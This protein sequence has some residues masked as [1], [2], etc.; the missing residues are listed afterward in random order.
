[1]TGPFKAPPCVLPKPPWHTPTKRDAEKMKA[2][3]KE[4]LEGRKAER[5]NSLFE[6]L[7]A[8]G[9]VD[10]EFNYEQATLVRRK[11]QDLIDEANE[12]NIEP[13]REAVRK[14][15][16]ELAD[17]IQLPKRGRGKRR[18]NTNRK[19][20]RAVEDVYFIR[21]LWKREYRGRWKRFRDNPPYAH[22]IAAEFHNVDPR[23]V[24][25]QAGKNRTRKSTI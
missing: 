7:E 25:S 18:H 13:L 14:V 3:T 24:K 20:E 5:L 15:I 10:F 21:E 8:H 23:T 16:P 1:V 2:W 6:E 4:R 9:G 11:F 19:V 22:E 12:G 17:F